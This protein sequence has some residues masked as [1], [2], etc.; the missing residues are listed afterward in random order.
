MLLIL[1]CIIIVFTLIPNLILIWLFRKKLHISD[2][3]GNEL[4][5]LF[6]VAPVLLIPLCYYAIF[7]INIALAMLGYFIAM[8]MLFIA[9]DYCI[10]SNKFSWKAATI[11][12]YLL[13][14]FT[15]TALYDY[16]EKA[17]LVN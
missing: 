14:C 7:R 2:K 11:P 13:L 5:P 3:T 9:I 8:C 6:L 17:I 16:F 4:G 1:L 10:K 15:E 12:Y